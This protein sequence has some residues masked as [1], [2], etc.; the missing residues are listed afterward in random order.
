MRRHAWYVALC[1]RLAWRRGIPDPRVVLDAV[2]TWLARAQDASGC[3]G[4]SAYYDL[5][6]ERWAAAYPETTGYI[7]P[8]LF[9]YAELTGDEEW[10]SRA[11]RMTDWETSI[12][13][14]DG[15]VQAGTL[16][17][18]AR[19]PTV[20]NTGQ[21]LFGWARA[22]RETGNVRYAE[23]LRR[24]ADWLVTCQDKDGAWRRFPSPFAK[25]GINA[26]N[27]RTAY[28]L[29]TAAQALGTG[30]YTEAARR[31]VAWALSTAQPNGWLPN[32]CLEDNSRPLTHTVAYAIRGILEVAAAEEDAGALAAAE[33][34][35][36]AVA[37][38]QRRDGSLP[39]RLDSGWRA[40]VRWSCVTGNAQMAIVWLRLAELLGVDDLFA[41]AE[42]AIGF[43]LG[44]V[45]LHAVD[46]GVRGGVKGAHPFDGGYMS[47]RYPNWAAKFLADA[48]MLK[49]KSRSA[50]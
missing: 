30:K 3:D 44:T 47:Y 48:I 31:N 28:G 18:P 33:H 8:T 35:A 37:S 36:R 26:Y 42:R 22:Y 39:G 49:S 2:L 19:V 23:A 17:A 29:T 9:D 4:V 46:P 40:A 7:I 43:C 6:T 15:A 25:A 24:A 32:N 1:D 12:Q 14:P 45:D 38:A 16:D 11:L 13:M 41:H 5:T 20:F 10:R 50:R 27:T 21:V 34:M